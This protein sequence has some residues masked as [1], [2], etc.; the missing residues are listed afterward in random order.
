[1]SVLLASASVVVGILIEDLRP[2]RA[3]VLLQLQSE[4]AGDGADALAR[5][6]HEERF[7]LFAQLPADEDDEHHGQHGH[8]QQREQGELCGK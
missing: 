4:T 5:G 1:M 3:V 7:E 6:G 8:V 2:L